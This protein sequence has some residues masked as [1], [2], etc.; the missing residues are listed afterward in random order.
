MCFKINFIFLFMGIIYSVYGAPIS[1]TD[2]AVLIDY[3]TETT[4]TEQKFA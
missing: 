4:D 3:K 2:A 1:D